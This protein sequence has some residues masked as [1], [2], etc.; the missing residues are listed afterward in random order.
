MATRLEADLRR[1]AARI[2]TLR[3]SLAGAT[4]R[5]NL[6]LRQGV[7]EGLPKTVLA[8]WAGVRRET[9]YYNTNGRD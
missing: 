9:V 4:E 3:A 5:R 1:S 2:E 7:E 6:L 8:E